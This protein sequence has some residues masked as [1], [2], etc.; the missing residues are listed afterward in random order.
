MCGDISSYYY[1]KN[2]SALLNTTK[3]YSLKMVK[4]VMN[5]CIFMHTYRVCVLN[6]FQEIIMYI[7]LITSNLVTSQLLTET[8]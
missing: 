7:R 8:L 1:V 2:V 3:K 4:T 6:N 5:E